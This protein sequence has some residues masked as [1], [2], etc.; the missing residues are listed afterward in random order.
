[1]DAKHGESSSCCH[2]KADGSKTKASGAEADP[3][4]IYMYPMHPEIE[5][6]GHGDCP[7]CGMD[8]EPKHVQPTSAGDNEPFVSMM[9]R[10]WIDLAFS[11]PLLT[12]A[13]GSM[14]GLNV[15]EWIGVTAF[16]WLQLVLATPVVFWC[17]WPL[18]VRGEKSFRTMNLNMF[19]LI[20]VGSL[21]AYLFSL[22]V[23]LVPGVVPAAFLENGSPPLYF[24]AAAVIIT[25]VLLGQVL[26]L[27]SRPSSAASCK[28]SPKHSEFACRFK[29]W[30]IRWPVNVG[31]AME[32]GAGVTL[33]GGDLRGV[34]AAINLSRKTMSNIRQNLFFAFAY[35]PIGIP[36]AARL[37]YPFL[38]V[39]LSP[40]IASAAMSFS[41]VSVIANALR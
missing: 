35:N 15:A 4:A 3:K 20:T 23:V 12:V 38:G 36:I 8:L 7:I 29:I 14:I 10:F 24:E 37:L 27:G 18:L 34:A 41:S 40:M 39:L 33:V 21:S 31:I 11:L 26:E 1:M 32:T 9:R 28:W 6:V 2:A 16:G 5:Q 30:Q 13:M 19:S 22:V 25:L 17:G